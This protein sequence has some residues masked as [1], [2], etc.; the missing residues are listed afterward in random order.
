M[1]A[2]SAI[3]LAGN[4]MMRR[5][6]HV[7]FR[8]KFRA[9]P[10]TYEKLQAKTVDATGITGPEE[11]SSPQPHMTSITKLT[12][13]ALPSRPRQRGTFR[14]QIFADSIILPGEDPDAFD[15]LHS[16]LIHLFNPTDSL[17]RDLVD[18]VALTQWRLKRLHRLEAAAIGRSLDNG[19]QQFRQLDRL[20]RYELRLNRNLR[21]TLA[22]LRAAQR[23]RCNEETR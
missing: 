17:Q 11:Q 6:G 15:A 18:V 3:F 12:A 10:I 8:T 20:G 9:L 2:E 21:N 4:G 7:H 16:S 22:M 1:Q 5:R 14:Q 13:T 23:H 19:D